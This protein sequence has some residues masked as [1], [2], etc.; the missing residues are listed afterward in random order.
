MWPFAATGG[1]PRRKRGASQNIE[2]V[3]KMLANAESQAG[4]V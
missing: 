3:G 1:R 2:V 4:N